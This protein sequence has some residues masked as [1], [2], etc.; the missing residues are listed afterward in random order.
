MLSDTRR[1]LLDE[2]DGIAPE[3]V[4]LRAGLARAWTAWEWV[5]RNAKSEGAQSFG[6]LVLG[7]VFDCLKKLDALPVRPKT[8]DGDSDSEDDDW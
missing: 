2:A 1:R 8:P 7:A 3:P 4:V 5:Q 6:L